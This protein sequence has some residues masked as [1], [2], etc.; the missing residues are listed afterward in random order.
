MDIGHLHELL[1][2]WGHPALL[3]LLLL[4]GVGSPIPEDLL[5]L[6]AGYLI[7]SGVLWWPLATAICLAGVIGSDLM[8]YGAG[9]RLGWSSSR[10]WRQQQAP[11]RL[12]RAMRLFDRLGPA[13]VIGARLVPGTRAIVFITAGVRALPA[14]QFLLCDLIGALLWVP[15]LLWAGHAVGGSIGGIDEAARLVRG[16]APWL[17]GL[18]VVLLALWLVWGRE[19]SKL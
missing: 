6:T 16:G 12:E 1:R 8:L 5:L 4:T 17:I 3:L 18:A 13:A 11:R 15:L 19:E 9:R 7:A 14:S 10:L 2:T